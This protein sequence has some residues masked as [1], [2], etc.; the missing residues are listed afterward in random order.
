MN[1][2]KDLIWACFKGLSAK[3]HNQNHIKA[4]LNN[5]L[6]EYNTMYTN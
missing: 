4:L 1:T 2:P 5:Q 3:I 6:S